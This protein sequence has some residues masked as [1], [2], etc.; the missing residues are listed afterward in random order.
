MQTADYSSASDDA[1]SLPSARPTGL[2]CARATR[3]ITVTPIV[4]RG[5]PSQNRTSL[6]DAEDGGEAEAHPS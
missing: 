6:Q 1:L 5:R 4:P 2:P 3:R